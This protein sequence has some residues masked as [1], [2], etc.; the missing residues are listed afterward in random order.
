MNNRVWCAVANSRP[1]AWIAFT[2]AWLGACTSSSRLPVDARLFC[3]KLAD[4]AAEV[5]PTC[6]GVDAS[7]AR[8][9]FEAEFKCERYTV[10]A[11]Q[12]R[13][14]PDKTLA[15]QC[16][17]AAKEGCLSLDAALQTNGV[18]RRAFAPNSRHA[19]DCMSAEECFDSRCVRS[20]DQCVGRCVFPADLGQAC[21]ADAA[22]RS[23][24]YC[25]SNNVCAALPRAGQPCASQ[26]CALGLDCVA[27][28]CT[29]GV[30]VGENCDNR[31]CS[32]PL[33]CLRADASATT[34]QCVSPY[35]VKEG[36]ASCEGTCGPLAACLPPDPEKSLPARCHLLKA[37]GEA[38]QDTGACRSQLRCDSTLCVAGL[39]APAKFNEACG[40]DAPAC[41][42]SICD[43]STG[44]C[45]YAGLGA[46]CFIH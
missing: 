4:A 41:L 19:D 13:V 21:Q 36:M 23:D 6:R 11:E 31:T 20:A 34:K 1:S 37:Q 46:G 32:A 43:P 16:L 30:G 22:C 29:A 33:L 44:T 26:R 9:Q 12:R 5:W 10:L 28:S 14:N 35:E 42:N 17:A 18:C 25:N 3:G 8:A 39:M 2:L 45:G 40:R 7:V 15:D 38:C 24:A 27:N